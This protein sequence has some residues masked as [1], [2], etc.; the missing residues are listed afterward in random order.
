MP[1]ISS[2][3]LFFIVLMHLIPAS[4]AARSMAGFYKD[5]FNNPYSKLGK[6]NHTML[7]NIDITSRKIL[8]IDTPQLIAKNKLD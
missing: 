8:I 6:L 3:I 7:Q 1:K 4:Y 5:G 2:A